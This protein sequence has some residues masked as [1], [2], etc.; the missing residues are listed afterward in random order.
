MIKRFRNRRLTTPPA[1]LASFDIDEL[2]S[3]LKEA[4]DKICLP[5]LLPLCPLTRFRIIHMFGLM[6]HSLFKN[7]RMLLPLANVNP[8]P[9]WT[10]L[11]TLS[12]A[13]FPVA[14]PQY[15]LTSSIL[16]L[17]MESFHQHG[18]IHYL[19]PKPQGKGF[20]PIALTSCILKLTEKMLLNRLQW[21]IENH[22]LLPEHQFGFRSFR[23]CLDNFTILTA[24]V[25]AGFLHHKHTAALFVDIKS[26]FDNVLPNLLLQDLA[27]LNIPPCTLKFI[28]NLISCRNVQFV[29]Q[30][31]L[32]PMRISR[33]GTPQ[34]AVLIPTLFNLYLRRISSIIHPETKIIQFADDIVL[35]STSSNPKLAAQSIQHSL[36]RMGDFLLQLG[37][38]ISPEKT[39][40]MVFTRSSKPIYSGLAISDR[41]TKINPSDSAKFLGVTLDPGL[42]GK[43]HLERVNNKT[44]KVSQVLSALREVWWGSPHQMLLNVY[45]ALCRSVMKYACHIFCLGDSRGRQKLQITQNSAI[46]T[47]LGLRISTP[48]NILF[49]E[50]Q[51]PPFKLRIRLLAY[52]YLLKTLSITDHPVVERFENLMILTDS[53][54]KRSYV[55]SNFPLISIFRQLHHLK[56][57]IHHTVILPKFSCTFASIFI[58]LEILYSPEEFSTRLSN[59]SSELARTLF[60]E[61]FREF[62]GQ[63]TIF[64]TDGSRINESSCVGAAW[65]SPHLGIEL[66]DRLPHYASIF[67]AEAWAIYNV[68]ISL[69]VYNVYDTVIVSDSKSILQA[70]KGAI[71]YNNNYLIRSLRL[72]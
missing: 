8:V 53:P 23:S 50:A 31:T 47:C 56:Q 24:D 13:P 11:T 64:Y 44:R 59:S 14:C 41:E 49:T 26:A 40:F 42:T 5:V 52:K 10:E 66:M 25:Q 45:R 16:C 46:R 17:D 4:M 34:G 37:L 36:K 29:M 62:I 60:L 33:K 35:Y 70:L 21:L 72:N 63:S 15:F 9:E 22:V 28:A 48:L 39:Q 54:A 2:D 69:K 32:H 6:T 61:T 27:S 19:I 65:H 7:L 71:L 68:V 3:P 30:G 58:S 18:Y 38:E 12:S 1:S 43:L 51:E 67:S 20:R 55:A 57:Q